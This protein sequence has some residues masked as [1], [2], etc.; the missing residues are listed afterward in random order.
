MIL[1]DKYN[2]FLEIA[3]SGTWIS[4]EFIEQGKRWNNA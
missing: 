3:S 2:L 4:Y 1:E